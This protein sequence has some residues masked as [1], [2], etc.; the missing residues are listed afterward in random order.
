MEGHLQVGEVLGRKRL[1]Q[2]FPQRL[3]RVQVSTRLHQP[4]RTP[5]Y[6]LAEHH[7]QGLSLP[8]LAQPGGRPVRI[9]RHERAVNR[10]DGRAD[11]QV[12][13]HPRVSERPQHPHLMR[14]KQPTAAKHEPNS[15]ASQAF[16]LGC[17]QTRR[18]SQARVGPVDRL[19]RDPGGADV[20]LQVLV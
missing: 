13:P 14:P 20:Q 7:P 6:V 17:L 19:R 1:G 8:Q 15:H 9:G 11:H 18:R 2:H 16:R 3:D 10:P 5:E 12:G 4:H